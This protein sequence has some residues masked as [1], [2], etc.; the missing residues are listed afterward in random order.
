MGLWSRMPDRLLEATCEDARAAAVTLGEEQEEMRREKRSFRVLKHVAF[1]L[2]V[3]CVTAAASDSQECGASAL[4]H[5]DSF[6]EFGSWVFT[7]NPKLIARCDGYQVLVVYANGTDMLFLDES[8]RPRI[9]TTHGPEHGMSFGEF[10]FYHAAYDIEAVSCEV[11]SPDK[12]QIAG[13][14][15]DH[16]DDSSFRFRIVADTAQRSYTYEDTKPK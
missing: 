11:L 16:H 7:A 13:T 5:P 12:V 4:C 10:N 14:A 15:S 3:P 6:L 8:A 2:S 9:G 1:L